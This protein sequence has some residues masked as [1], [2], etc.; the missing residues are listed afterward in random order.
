MSAEPLELERVSTVEALSRALRRRILDGGLAPGERLREVEI[1]EAYGVGRYTVRSAFQE[2]VYRGMA[3]HAPNRG[4]SVLEPTASIIRDLYAYRAG[5][6]CEAARLIVERGL[7]L[8][9]SKR[10]LGRLGELPDDAPWRELLEADLAIHRAI[11]DTVGSSRMS[12]A[13]ESIVDQVMLCLSRL[14]APKAGVVA[15]HERLI[16]ALGSGDADA[17]AGALRAHLYQVVEQMGA[18]DSVSRGAPA[19]ARAGAARKRPPRGR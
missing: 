8:D 12:R 16:S 11:V 13:F 2:L 7:S 18:G 4:V 15:D 10:A 1:A 5:L 19:R 17:A 6:E 14:N 3:E 9:R